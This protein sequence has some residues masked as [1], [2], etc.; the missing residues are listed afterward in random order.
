MGFIGTLGIL[1]ILAALELRTTVTRQL[2]EVDIQ[3]LGSALREVQR[4][5]FLL[6]FLSFLLTS[7]QMANGFPWCGG[8][9]CRSII[10]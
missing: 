10:S 7:F 3:C 8:S 5:L 4:T 1:P 9:C 6:L 2:H